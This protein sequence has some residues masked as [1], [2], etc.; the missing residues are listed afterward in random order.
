MK[1]ILSI[2][3]FLAIKDID[4]RTNTNNDTQVIITPTTSVISI[5]PIPEDADEEI[6]IDVIDTG[7]PVI[8]KVCIE[9]RCKSVKI[10]KKYKSTPVPSKK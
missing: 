6:R 7:K 10:H 2:I 3:L 9:G 1:Q 4:A 8:K 5:P